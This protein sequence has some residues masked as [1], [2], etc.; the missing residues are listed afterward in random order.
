MDPI[1]LR[2]LRSPG[3][4]P[5]GMRSPQADAGTGNQYVINFAVKGTIDLPYVCSARGTWTTTSAINGRGGA[6]KS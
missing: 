2:S 1:L 5:F 4:P 6:S 3:K